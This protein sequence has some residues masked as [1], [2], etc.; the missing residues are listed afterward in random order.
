VQVIGQGESVPVI[1]DARAK[2]TGRVLAP[3]GLR[4]LTVNGLRTDVD[5]DGIFVAQLS[6]PPPGT[7]D[8]VVQIL[9]VDIQ[10]KRDA[11][12]LAIR[13]NASLAV[14][15]RSAVPPQ[16]AALFGRYF[17][18]VIG[19]DHYQHWPP[20]ANGIAD[21]AAIAELLQLRYGFTVTL[22]K[23]AGRQQILKAL[24]E[25]RKTLTEKDNLLIYYAGHGHLE[26]GIER[27]YWIPVDGEVHDNTN[28]IQL[29]NVT[30]LLQLMTAKH[31]MVVADSCFGGK[32]T[33][34][35]L[36]Q[37]RPGLTDDARFNLLK[38]L[39]QKRVRT[40]MTSGGVDPVLDTGGAGHSVFAEAFLGVLR[41]N[42]VIME[43]ERLFWAI[44]TR[45]LA[46]SQTL[47]LEQL[48]T[49]DPIHMAGHESLGDFIFVPLG[50]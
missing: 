20:L 45:V 40:A 29:P 31:V 47:H 14:T 19:N 49:Y 8:V 42:A 23:D 38:T 46:R 7:E 22:L 27:G 13:A 4:S 35:T 36:A 5:G 1:M 41:E 17:A 48:P 43:A 3:A 24:N 6:A 16:E 30:D 25:L 32:L 37:L 33:R 39:A 28:W 18:L 26:Q 44:R 11:V 2:I 9:A 15:S 21:A 34:N 50:L 12:R 10:N